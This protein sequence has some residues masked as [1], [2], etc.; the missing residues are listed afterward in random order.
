VM[1]R[2]GVGVRERVRRRVSR[3]SSRVEELGTKS[4]SL[5]VTL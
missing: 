5:F 2:I 3:V 1:N 4:R